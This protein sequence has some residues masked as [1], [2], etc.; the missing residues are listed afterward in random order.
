MLT[1]IFVEGITE[2]V[3]SVS[4]LVINASFQTLYCTSTN[5]RFK[6]NNCSYHRTVQ[7]KVTVLIRRVSTNVTLCK[8]LPTLFYLLREFGKCI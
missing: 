2:Y 8:G 5:T 4:I 6:N 7:I 1:K 3:N